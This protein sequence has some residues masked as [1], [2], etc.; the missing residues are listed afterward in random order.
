MELFNQKNDKVEKVELKPFKSEKEIQSLVEK[1][2]DTFFQLEFIS[3]ELTV[4]SYRIDTL[5]Y[6]DENDSFVIIEYKK[7]TSYS[8]MDQGYTYLQ[9]LL[10]NKS[11][12]LL[13]LSQRF[14]KVLQLED[15]DWRQSKLIFV[16]QTFNSFQTDSIDSKDVHFELWEIKRFSNNTIV[17]NKHTSSSNES[18]ES[19]SNPKNKNIISS[20]TKEIKVKDESKHLSN[21][22]E[23]VLDKWDNL[24]DRITEFVNIGIV[25]KN[26]Y[27][28]WVC[29]G[30]ILCYFT[31][32]KD[33]ITLE[34]RRGTISLDRS[35]SKNYFDIDD[36]K[37]ISKETSWKLRSG[38]EGTNYKISITKDVDVDYIMFLIRQKYNNLSV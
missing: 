37:G 11:D 29:L 17:L 1:N 34:I 38:I 9:L 18:I 19:L 15:I 21:C 12:F 25:S 31:F 23:G 28:N 30:K 33:S 14:D 6:D 27:I 16:S 3:S 26:N 10:N 4:G 13:N 35:K 8:V 22:S 20:V 32:K 36:P 2:T 24:K 7:G 5:C